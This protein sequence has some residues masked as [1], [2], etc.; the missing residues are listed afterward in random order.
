MLWA[1]PLIW[2]IKSYF[3]SMFVAPWITTQQQRVHN[4]NFPNWSD[5][6]SKEIINYYQQGTLST[7]NGK[8]K[9]WSWSALAGTCMA[10]NMAKNH[11]YQDFLVHLKKQRNRSDKPGT[12]T[13]ADGSTDVDASVRE[14]YRLA[15]QMKTDEWFKDEFPLMKKCDQIT[16]KSFQKK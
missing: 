16:D 12:L 15:N 2:I 4:F 10:E 1:A 9:G 13:K 7:R 6:E 5:T 3:G 8:E 14:V 11:V